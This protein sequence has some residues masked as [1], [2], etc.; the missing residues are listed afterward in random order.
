MLLLELYI[1]SETIVFVVLRMQSIMQ[2]EYLVLWL[3]LV[4]L[5]DM[6]NELGPKRFLIPQQ[7]WH[8]MKQM[9][10]SMLRILEIIEFEKLILPRTLLLL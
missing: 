10:F 6:L 9:D 4:G 5:Q 2:M 8:L 7:I 1:L 3:E